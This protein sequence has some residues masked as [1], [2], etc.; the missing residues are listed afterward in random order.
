MNFDAQENKTIKCPNIYILFMN[1]VHCPH[2][3]TMQYPKILPYIASIQYDSQM[4]IL[5]SA[6]YYIYIISYLYSCYSYTC[7]SSL[8]NAL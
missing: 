4:I 2:N 8:G 5:Y 6:R 1:N 3:A 7:V